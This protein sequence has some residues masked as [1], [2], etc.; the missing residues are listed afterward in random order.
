MIFRFHAEWQLIMVSTE[1]NCF[2]KKDCDVLFVLLL[3]GG[4]MDFVMSE[5]YLLQ[6][7]IGLFHTA[8]SLIKM[9]KYLYHF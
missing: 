9:V 3:V 7:S 4:R 1:L 8:I 6:Q 5:L 2:M